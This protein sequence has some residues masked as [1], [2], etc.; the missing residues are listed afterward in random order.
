MNES[1]LPTQ[2][3]PFTSK[4]HNY[5]FFQLNQIRTEVNY[6]DSMYQFWS[7]CFLI[8]STGQCIRTTFDS[9]RSMLKPFVHIFTCLLIIV[10]FLTIIFFIWRS[11][12]RKKQGRL[13]SPRSPGPLLTY[14]HR[15]SA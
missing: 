5:L 3:K 9:H 11:C 13:L 15:V 8:E 14:P 10:V 2:W 7:E 12:H 4:E 1:P 6:F